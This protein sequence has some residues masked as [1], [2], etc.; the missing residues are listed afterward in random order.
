MP[1][2]TGRTRGRAAAAFG[3]GAFVV[4]AATASPG[5]ATASP[6]PATAS[7][8]VAPTV[9]ASVRTAVAY[10]S[11]HGMLSGVAVLDTRTGAL[12][13]AGQYAQHFP[14][15]SVVK[16]LIATRLLVEGRMHGTDAA[17]ARLMITESDNAAAQ[18]LYGQVGGDGLLPWLAAHY[19]IS[20]LGRRPTSPGAWGTTQLTARGLV[21]FYAAVRADPVVWPWLRTELHAYHQRSSDGEFNAFGIAEAA[22]ASGVK[23]GWAILD[24]ETGTA[25]TVI[26]TTGFVDGDRY[27]VAILADGAPSLFSARGEALVTTQA[28]DVMPAGVITPVP[29][30]ALTSLS[31][32]SGPVAGG[33]LIVVRGTGFAHVSRV[34]FGAVAGTSVRVL[35]THTL[36]VVV[37]AG[38]AGQ[39]NVRV[40]GRYGTSAAVIADRYTYVAP[41]HA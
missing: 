21:R 29:P 13:V 40:V 12:Y 24:D 34:R 27:A 9:A 11:S 28:R 23:N 16:A 6:G 36:T 30:P 22:P 19:R 20:G 17:L 4:L 33:A 18:Q 5:P 1:G 2:G 38:A 8:G 7:S 25:R 10:G 3:A 15:A 39:V 32:M 31:V 26:N 35:A 14:S 41:A 37:P